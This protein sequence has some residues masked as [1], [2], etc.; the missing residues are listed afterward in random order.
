LLQSFSPGVS[1]S[2]LKISLQNYRPGNYYLAF[3]GN[4]GQ[5][6]TVRRF[7]KRE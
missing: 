1:I 7:I 6:N 3:I 4:D 5:S 2:R